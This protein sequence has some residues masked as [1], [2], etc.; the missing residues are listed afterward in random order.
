LWPAQ[1]AVGV[2]EKCR[3][4]RSSSSE[5]INGLSGPPKLREEETASVSAKKSG[6]IFMQPP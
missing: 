6:R 3:H 4:T 5:F 2:R 1:T